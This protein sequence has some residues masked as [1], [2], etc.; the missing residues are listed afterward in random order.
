MTV[1]EAK[2]LRP[3]RRPLATRP[4]SRRMTLIG[5]AAGLLAAVGG[6]NA[7]QPSSAAPMLVAAAQVAPPSSVDPAK[8]V[9]GA[10]SVSN[11]D[12]KRGDG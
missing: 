1:L 12:F 7:A 5:L 2:S 9:P 4:A 3:A 10:I 8:Q 11:I 6:V